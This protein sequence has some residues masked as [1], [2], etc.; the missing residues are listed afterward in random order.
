M[1]VAIGSD[2]VLEHAT[3]EGVSLGLLRLRLDVALVA[4][5]RG[6]AFLDHLRAL[7]TDLVRG[8]FSL[9]L[10]VSFDGLAGHLIVSRRGRASGEEQ[11]DERY[12]RDARTD[13]GAP[14]R[15]TV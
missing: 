9:G 2:G 5:V 14:H 4:L 7:F 15:R 12:E 3:L 6:A 8:E 11:K 13:T 10:A 1:T